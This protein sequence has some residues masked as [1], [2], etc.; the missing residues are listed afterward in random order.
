MSQD[1]DHPDYYRPDPHADE[2]LVPFDVQGYSGKRSMWLLGLLVLA[3]LALLFFLF[4]AYQP[5]VRDRAEAPKII[6]EKTPYKVE[7]EDPGGEEVP[8]QDLEIYDALNGEGTE[9]EIKLT[10]SSEEPV[11]RPSVN[12]EIK[13]RNTDETVTE[14]VPAPRPVEAEPAPAPSTPPPVTTS[15]DS[16]HV[17]QLAS[18]RSR[19]SAEDTWNQVQAKHG[20]L[21]PSGSYADI[22][23]ADVPNKGVYYRLRLAGMAD[24]GTAERI[25]ETL[26]ARNQSCFVTLK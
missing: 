21:L 17:V 8:N 20:T 4:K 15:G 10:E 26:K 11:E 6:A 3:L 5:G 2:E 25:C 16:R 22:I 13:D 24:K 19:E 1:Q 18:L 14:T 7:P 12:I 9:K 23:R